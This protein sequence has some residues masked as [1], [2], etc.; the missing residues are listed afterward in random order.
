[1]AR[2]EQR[3]DDLPEHL[4]WLTFAGLADVR[5]GMVRR[6]F[7]A[8]VQAVANDLASAPDIATARSITITI[9]AKPTGMDDLGNLA[10]V[11]A[12]LH[13]KTTTP[14]R[15]ANLALEVRERR[16]EN[17]RPRG[18]GLAHNPDNADKPA[19]RSLFRRSDDEAA[20]E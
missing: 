9:K 6:M 19:Q 2:H 17:G 8:A 3:L 1:M 4:D 12:G 14:A 13:I 7:E 15:E 18:R 10:G 11:M 5:G 20:D 16:D